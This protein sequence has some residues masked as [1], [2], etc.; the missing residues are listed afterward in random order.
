MQTDPLFS[1]QY[2]QQASQ[3]INSFV[4]LMSNKMDRIKQ[5]YQQGD[6]S[7]E[8]LEKGRQRI[9]KEAADT[10]YVPYTDPFR[11]LTHL[12]G[13]EQYQRAQLLQFSVSSF[14]SQDG[15]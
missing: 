3:T 7:Y 4:S 15:E 11:I 8:Q 12:T 6:I 10:L 9:L 13:A 2:R 5:A 1:T 14:L